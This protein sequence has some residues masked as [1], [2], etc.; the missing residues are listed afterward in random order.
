MCTEDVVEG[1]AKGGDWGDIL[2]SID[3][4]TRT[5][6]FA[7]SAF[8]CLFALGGEGSEVTGHILGCIDDIVLVGKAEHHDLCIR[9][10]THG[11]IGT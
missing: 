2:L 3:V 5:L 4:A 7:G 10:I 11:F 8:L 6:F 1:G 9:K